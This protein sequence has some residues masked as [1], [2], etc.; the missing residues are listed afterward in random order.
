MSYTNTITYYPV[1]KSIFDKVLRF[2]AVAEM[3]PQK[4]APASP[5]YERA[6]RDFDHEGFHYPAPPVY[7]GQVDMTPPPEQYVL[8][9][10]VKAPGTDIFLPMAMAWMLPLLH[11]S[12]DYQRAHFPDFDNRFI[13]ITVRSGIVKSQR[14]DEFHVDGFQGTSVPRHI[15]EQ[16]YIWSNCHPTEFVLQPFFIDELDPAVHNVHSYL[17][18]MTNPD[19]IVEVRGNGAYIMDPYHVHRRP[20]I[21]AGTERAFI[22]ICYSPVEIKDD[23]NTFNPWIPMGPYNRGDVRNKLIDYPG[24]QG[25]Q[26]GLF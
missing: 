15:P 21:P 9:L 2:P 7:L 18:R 26:A 19:N 8:R 6:T 4:V 3:Q 22:R 23:T 14:D 17:D 25:N 13:Y 5:V 16:N 24:D 11:Q 20:Q 1:E 12:I 10:L